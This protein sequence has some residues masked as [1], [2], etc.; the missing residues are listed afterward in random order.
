MK[1]KCFTY[2]ISDAGLE[3][4]LQEAPL[5]TLESL[6]R[7]NSPS[8]GEVKLNV[9]SK[10]TRHSVPSGSSEGEEEGEKIDVD[11]RN[12][13]ILLILFIL[14]RTDIYMI[15]F[16]CMHVDVCLLL[17][18]LYVFLMRKVAILRRFA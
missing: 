15:V 7:T 14:L 18:I 10:K 9:K 12:I 5:L 16:R 6:L 8:T 11:V 3:S 1:V 13:C 2:S 4:G 17:S